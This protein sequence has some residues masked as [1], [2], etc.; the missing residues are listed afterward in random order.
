MKRF[1][2]LALAAFA[3]TAIVATDTAEARRL[4][5]GRSLGNV[6]VRVV[7][8]HEITVSLRK[9]EKANKAD[10]AYSGWAGSHVNISSYDSLAGK[11]VTVKAGDFIYAPAGTLHGFQG[12]SESPAR[13]LIVDAPAHTEG[14]FKDCDREVKSPADFSK[15]PAIGRRHGI[16][17]AAPA[18]VDQ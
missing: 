17:F 12:V 7:F 11:S 2:I 5:G 15:M 13:L 14:F 10:K 6:A 4:G 8:S 1:L 16:R 18:S 3:A 9:T